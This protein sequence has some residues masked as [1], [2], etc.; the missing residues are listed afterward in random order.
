[1]ADVADVAD[2]AGVVG[3]C[4]HCNGTSGELNFASVNGTPIWLHVGCKDAYRH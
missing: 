3:R 4:A 1:V 2:A